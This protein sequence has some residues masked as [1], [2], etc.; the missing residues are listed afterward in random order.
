[1]CILECIIILSRIFL[2]GS[3]LTHGVDEDPGNLGSR[4]L[5]WWKLAITQHLSNFC[6]TQHDMVFAAVRTGFL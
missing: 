4:E 6:T 3:R 5:T 2:G 1:M